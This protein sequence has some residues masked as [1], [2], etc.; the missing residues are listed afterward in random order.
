MAARDPK[1]IIESM[2]L[3][4]FIVLWSLYI[5]LNCVFAISASVMSSNLS[6]EP[7]SHFIF[8]ILAGLSLLSV[9]KPSLQRFVV[10]CC[11][12]VALAF[13]RLPYIG[14]HGLLALLV[15]LTFVICT[16]LTIFGAGRFD[17]EKIFS[18]FRPPAIGLVF[19]LY[20]FA[21]FHKLN[22]DYLDPQV[23]C[24]SAFMDW[25]RARSFTFL[26]VPGVWARTAVIYVSLGCEF[27][28]PVLLCF[29][30]TLFWGLLLAFTFHFA[31][32]YLIAWHFSALM[33][34]LL[35]L[36]MPTS[37]TAAVLKIKAE[38]ARPEGRFRRFVGI[39]LSVILFLGLVLPATISSKGITAGNLA[40]DPEW[41]LITAMG[42]MVFLL[43]SLAAV[44]V[45][46]SAR[47]FR[48]LEEPGG[49]HFKLRI[50]FAGV[51]A[52]AV[53]ALFPYLGLSTASSFSMFS[54]LRT[55]GGSS[56]HLFM[57]VTQIF[58]DNLTDL[59]QIES[60]SPVVFG[61]LPI[62]EKPFGV[63]HP[64][65][66]WLQ[67]RKMI[68][69]ARRYAS[70]NIAVTYIRNGKRFVVTDAANDAAFT[71]PLSWLERKIYSFKY[72]SESPKAC[73]W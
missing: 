35:F 54:N 70:N 10:L 26:P 44:S 4:V 65:Y 16:V 24:A 18:R 58:S 34:A 5:Y 11:A 66:P 15:D 29:R 19:C 9:L 62:E 40:Y 53:I 43:Y 42:W 28:I 3:H 23:S 50:E 12:N 52:M 30:R 69:Y 61:V 6:F 17:E 1:K 67:L 56:N 32:G 13:Y 39:F 55:E 47:K 71:E 25:L 37:L 51:L 7:L 22:W 20:L 46:W 72:I 36:F 38:L 59:V 73:P 68:D 14:N 57:P 41:N 27:L 2:P 49:A 48:S 21:T 8:S 60:I 63:E 31:I 33:Y 64:M 45:L